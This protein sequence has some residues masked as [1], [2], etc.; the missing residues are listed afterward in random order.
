MRTT[1]KCPRCNGT[2]V[3]TWASHVAN[4]VCFACKGAGKIDTTTA[5]LDEATRACVAMAQAAE[6]ERARAC[7]YKQAAYLNKIANRA[8]VA[9]ANLLLVAIGR[10]LNY[11]P[12]FTKEAVSKALDMFG[13]MD[14]Q[15][16]RRTVETALWGA[17]R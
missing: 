12:E 8:G 11:D 5:K 4:G 10:G 6:E 9:D 13:N 3:I 1:Y 17:G 15:K 16:V 7:T 2:G 14:P